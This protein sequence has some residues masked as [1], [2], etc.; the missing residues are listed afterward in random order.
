MVVFN[1]VKFPKQRRAHKSKAPALS[2]CP[3][4][5]GVVIK[6]FETTPR[7]PNSAK[8]KVAKVVLSN[9][10]KINVYLEGEG[11]NKLNPHSVVLVR[12]RG[13]RDLPGVRYHAIR[14]VKDFPA[15]TNRTKGRS[16]YG[17]KSK[18]VKV[19]WVHHRRFED[20]LQPKLLQYPCRKTLFFLPKYFSTTESLL[21]NLNKQLC[22]EILPE[23]LDDCINT[24]EGTFIIG[25]VFTN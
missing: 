2:F 22:E 17:I 12:G 14:G 10:R 19:E 23:Y 8:R 4:K 16:K 25:T 20:R 5:R 15:L 24:H 9:K 1:L 3:Q 18:K 6:S 7:K 11:T 13:P 21:L